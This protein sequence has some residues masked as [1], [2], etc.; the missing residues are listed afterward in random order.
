MKW[1]QEHPIAATDDAA[2]LKHEV[3]GQKREAMNT[4][5]ECVNNY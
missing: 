5:R 2:F 1:L 3:A 4:L